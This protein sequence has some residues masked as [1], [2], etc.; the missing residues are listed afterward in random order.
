MNFAASVVKWSSRV[1]C[2]I[3]IHCSALKLPFHPHSVDAF[4]LLNV[5]HHIPQPEI[6]FQEI[7][8]CLKVDGKIIM[9]EPANTLWARWIYQKFH[10]E[11]FDALA[12]WTID[13]P[14][15]LSQANIALPWIIFFRDR[16]LFEQ[17]C[18]QLSIEHIDI[19]TP[20]RY[21]V[22]GGFSFRQLL[23]AFSYPIIQGLEKILSPFNQYLGM[24]MT[25]KLKK[26]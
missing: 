8:Q 23:P 4:F 20:F 11:P 6:F 5:L 7:S 24:F 18:P 19:H 15:P 2:V 21:L 13:N 1:S 25:I 26:R 22:S 12:F 9:I 16:K 3:D 14:G 10:H 17:K